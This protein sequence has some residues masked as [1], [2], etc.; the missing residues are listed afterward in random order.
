MSYENKTC[1]EAKK[2]HMRMHYAAQSN[3]HYL[4]L[5]SLIPGS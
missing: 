5:H 2:T 4:K 1:D 3:M